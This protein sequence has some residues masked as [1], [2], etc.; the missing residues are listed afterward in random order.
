M[1]EPV[2]V[3]N[4][5]EQPTRGKGLAPIKQ[6]FRK[7]KW[8]E[9][10]EVEDINTTAFGDDEVEG[11]KFEGGDVGKQSNA[12]GKSKARGQNKKRKRTHVTDGI[13]LCPYIAAGDNDKC[14]WGDKCK[15]THDIE[16]YL[17]LKPADLGDR[18]VNFE[19]YGRCRAGYACR[20]L[21]AHFKDGKLV[22]DE[23]VCAY[24]W[25]TSDDLFCTHMYSVLSSHSAKEMHLLLLR[26]ALRPKRWQL[27]GNTRPA[28]TI[29]E[30][31]STPIQDKLKEV[32]EVEQITTDIETTP[33]GTVTSVGTSQMQTEVVSETTI[34]PAMEEQPVGPIFDINDKKKVNFKDK[35]YL[36]P[37]TTVGNLPFRRICKEFG[38]DITCGEMAMATNLLQG[39]K[40]EWALTKRHASEDLFGIQIAG[41]KT[42]QLVKACQVINETVDVDFV[43][44]NMGCPIDM[45]F[46]KGGGSALLDSHGK[47]LKML[48]GMQH[49]LDPP[50][51][52]KFR[53]G[54]KDNTPTAH[55]LIPKLESVGIGMG[56]LHGRSRQQRYTRLADWDYIKGIK[57]L[58]NDMAL[59]GNGDVMSWEQYYQQKEESGVDGIMIGRGALI[60]PWIFEEIKTRRHWDISSSERFDMLKRFCDYG[61]EHWGTDTMGINSTRRF[62][63]EW[64]SFLYRY[65]PVGLLEVLPQHMNERPPPYYG[66]DELET[67]MASPRASDWIKITDRLLGP[68]PDDF[69]F[70]P[71]HKANSFEG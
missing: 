30:A 53:T 6:E 59:F 62:L 29:V 9:D 12:G 31:P 61:L 66:R 13:K 40:T 69:K 33:S 28:S 64:Q 60:K 1:S 23:E 5:V 3:A 45:L 68:A 19:V 10:N 39:Q 67:L 49:V 54:V 47:M 26:M 36:A 24:N 37:L 48:R 46:N 41:Y 55:K 16:E 56:T 63:C 44:L 57:R 15:F 21:Q 43:D 34:S 18:C 22:A 11:Q 65:I 35:T 38:V 71:K 42:E 50:V 58:T 17:K 2:A 20:Y 70:I 25:V 7:T 32:A 4:T 14:N 27:C 8:F 52:V 51:T